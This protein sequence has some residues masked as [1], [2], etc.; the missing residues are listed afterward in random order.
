MNLYIS[1]CGSPV[2]AKIPANPLVTAASK[3]KLLLKGVD[4]QMM[5]FYGK[6][7]DCNFRILT[8][9]KMVDEQKIR[10]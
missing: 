2:T 4:E 10:F 9:T 6:Y 1:L 5:R 7:V 3:I 8:S